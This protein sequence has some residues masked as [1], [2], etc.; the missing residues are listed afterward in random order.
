[1][2]VLISGASGLIGSALADDLANAGWVVARLVRP[3]S[4]GE[5]GIEES[6]AWDPAGGEIDPAGLAG[7]DAVVHL[8]GE[9]IAGRWNQDKKDRILQ[10]RVEG[11]RVLSEALAG[12]HPEVRP[13]VLVSA[14]AIGFY[15]D[16]G[17][18]M[19]SEDAES[20]GMFLSE[21]CRQWE[22]AAEPAG[23][24][25]IRVVHPR[26]GVVLSGRGGALP[27]MARPFRMGFGGRVGSGKQYVSWVS[28]PDT[29][30]ALRKLIDDASLHGPVNVTAPNPVTNAELTH[31]LGRRLHRPT[32]LPAPAFALRLALGEMADELLLASARVVPRKLLDAGF[33]FQYPA[34]PEALAE[35]LEEEP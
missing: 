8:A 16:R 21:V 32:V 9:P 17:D 12:L 14:S 28:L 18:E 35:A 33:E 15:G 31:W 24:S 7:F 23:E 1:M 26:L 10:S 27:A 22:S 25:G 20:G 13:R 3:A 29:V 6:V 11:T 5:E 34:L 4:S 19:L 30:A 2:R